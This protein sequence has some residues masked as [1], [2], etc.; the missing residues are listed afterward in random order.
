MTTIEAGQTPT[1]S[2]ATD[3]WPSLQF[4]TK[5]HAIFL[6]SNHCG[7]NVWLQAWL[8]VPLMPA[9]AVIS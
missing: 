3:A 8:V 5:M 1:V 7:L 6:S 9:A 4:F 2:V